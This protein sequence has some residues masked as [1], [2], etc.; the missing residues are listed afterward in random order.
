M[1]N[2]IEYFSKVGVTDIN[3]IA[4]MILDRHIYGPN[5]DDVCH[6]GNTTDDVINAFPVWLAWR[7]S[8]LQDIK[9]TCNL[10]NI[11]YERVFNVI[12]KRF[13]IVTGDLYTVD[14]EDGVC[15][16]WY[17]FKEDVL[18]LTRDNYYIDKSGKQIEKFK[19]HVPYSYEQIVEDVYQSMPD[20]YKLDEPAEDSVNRYLDVIHRF[21]DFH[22]KDYNK[23]THR[24]SL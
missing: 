10:L 20:V 24:S 12:C 23:L 16:H 3:S 9:D 1:E 5:S 19:K 21:I 18:C 14:K 11:Q 22:E 13:N 8:T 17:S 15:M 6:T 7:E 4:A 2:V